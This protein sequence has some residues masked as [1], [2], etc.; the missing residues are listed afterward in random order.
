MSAPAL[1][2]ATR[3]SPLALWQA[4][5]VAALL[6]ER[7]GRPAELVL[8]STAGDRDQ[9]SELHAIGG[10]GVFVKEV[11]QAVLAGD[12]DL[13]VH[14]AKDLP[15]LT[16]EGLVLA[17]VPERADARD[18]L[19]GATLATLRPGARVATGAVRRRAQLA[20]QRPDLV[21]ANLR[22]NIATRLALAER[23]DAIVMAAAALARLGLVPAV[24]DPLGV[25]VMVPQVGQGALAVECRADDAAVV[26][27]LAVIDDAHAARA[28]AAERAFLAALGGACD[29]PVGAHARLDGDAVVLDAVAADEVGAP[30]RRATERG[31]DPL[32]VG[33]AAAA[34]VGAVAGGRS[35]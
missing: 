14:S 5:R 16:P 1:R 29:L 24:A 12:A 2:I 3:S 8:V 4:E 25:D 33:R 23:F 7:A 28:V 10:Q 26:D 32:A 9:H 6:R 22:G 13:A 18:V 31:T 17:A 27:T 35:R 30:V 21:F 19:V 11:Q 34:A 20:A 15:A